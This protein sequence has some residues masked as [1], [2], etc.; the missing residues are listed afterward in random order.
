MAYEGERAMFEAFSRNKYTSTGVIQWMLNNAWPG[1]MYHLYDYYLDP[2]GA[3]FGAKKGNEP[4]H[5]MYSY[6]DR[7]IRVVNNDYVPSTMLRVKATVL[8][9]SL[10]K[11]FEKEAVVDVAADSSVSAFTI[12][13]TKDLSTTYFI[14]LELKDQRDESVSENFYWLSTKPDVI[15]WE[16]DANYA[17]PTSQYS[18]LTALGHLPMV[19]LERTAK[20]RPQGAQISLKNKSKTLAF[21]VHLR[22]LKGNGGDDVL[23]ILWDDNYVSILPGEQRQFTAT[24]RASD[25]GQEAPVVSLDG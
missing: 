11:R 23:P 12:P 22:I 25:L 3:Y 19:A 13:E 21:I 9:F 16:R 17:P 5:V 20:S 7:S 18:D 2:G 4:V 8:E 1:I 14:R 24:F 10:T 15:D 6:D